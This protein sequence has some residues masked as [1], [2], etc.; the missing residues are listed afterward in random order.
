[1]QRTHPE[2]PVVIPGA[3]KSCVIIADSVVQ[4]DNF[5]DI[6]QTIFCRVP[7]RELRGP[8]NLLKSGIAGGRAGLKRNPGSE[9]FEYIFSIN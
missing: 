5:F 2:M 8:G 6:N 3:Q 4:S 1:M 7:E 9:A